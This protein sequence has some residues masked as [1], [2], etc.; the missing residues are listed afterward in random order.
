MKDRF[1]NR[2][3]KKAKKGMR[4]WPAATIAFYGPDANRASKVV[5]G[6]IASEHTE[7]G[8]MR[9]WKLDAG[10]VR[11]DPRIAEEMLEFMARHGVLSVAMTDR[12]IGC[13]HQEGIDYHGQWCPVCEFWKGRD[14]F[15]GERVY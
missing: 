3:R 9:D 7:V 12:I 2:L 6:I 10:D 15:T 5:V 13:P 8:E 4:G 11:N 1:L 14:R